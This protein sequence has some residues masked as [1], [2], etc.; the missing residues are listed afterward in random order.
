MSTQSN[1]IAFDQ[2]LQLRTKFREEKRSNNYSRVIEISLQIIELEKS[3]KFIS[4]M[5]A[6]FLKEIGNAYIK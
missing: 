6:I 3:A 5:A 1:R 2:W 4:I